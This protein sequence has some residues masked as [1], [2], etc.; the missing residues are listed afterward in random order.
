MNSVQK[1]EELLMNYT[2]IQE[3]LDVIAERACEGG[4]TDDELANIMIGLSG[5]LKLK[6]DRL[7]RAYE[8]VVHDYY[9]L[10]YRTE[11]GDIWQK[12]GE[13]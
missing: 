12:S 7:W 10:S 3:D 1:F 13:I 8:K 9:Q 4:L 2:N 6:F 5:M 11:K